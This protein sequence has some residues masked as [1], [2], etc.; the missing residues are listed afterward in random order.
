VVP[1][2]G[3]DVEHAIARRQLQQ[4]EHPGNDERLGD[5]L[6]FFDRQGD[7][8]P[9]AVAMGGGH[10]AIARHRRD[11]GQHALVGHHRRQFPG[12]CLSRVHRVGDL[13]A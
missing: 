2:A 4:L 13:P 12:E 10:E 5:R 8:R 9:G 11:R 1:R 3:P 6:A 7:I